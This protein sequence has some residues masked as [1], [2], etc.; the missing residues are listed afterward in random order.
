[1]SAS[2]SL[3]DADVTRLSW[4]P[5]NRVASSFVLL[6]ALSLK[7]LDSCFSVCGKRMPFHGLC[8]ADCIRDEFGLWCVKSTIELQHFWTQ[9]HT[10]AHTKKKTT[11]IHIHPRNCTKFT[12]H[13]RTGKEYKLCVCFA[14][15]DRS[16]E[17]SE[18]QTAT[19][20]GNIKEPGNVGL[21]YFAINHKGKTT[22]RFVI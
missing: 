22:S 6:A 19:G 11:H 17:T 8:C 21:H 12:F 4:H 14:L 16:E 7:R 1:M 20:Y 15:L 9:T 5:S 13:H 2:K 10:H 18:T 3:D